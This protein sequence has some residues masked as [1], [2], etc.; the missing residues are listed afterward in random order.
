MRYELFD[1][2]KNAVAELLR[3]MQSMRRSYEEDDSLSAVSLTAPTGAGKTVVSAAVAEGLFYG[4]DLF[5]GD[6]RAVILWLSDS[7]SLNEQT[8]KRFDRATDLLSG[9]TTMEAIGPEFA[10]NHRKLMP[11]HVYFLNRQLLSARGRLANEAEG[12]RTFYDVLSETIEDPDIHLFL[13]IDEAHRGLGGDAT[14]DATNKTIYAKLIDGQDGKNPPMPIVVGISATP[15][16]F[17]AAMSGR[18]NRDTKAPVNVPVSEV[19]ESGLIKDTIELRTPK[20]AADTKHQDL[21]LACAKLAQASKNWKEYCTAHGISPVVIP[22]MVVQVEDKVSD[23]TLEA[24]CAQIHK[25]LPWLDISDCFA[26]VFGE[27]EDITTPAG[28]IPYCPPEDVAERTEIRVLFAKD[29]VSTGWDCP[30]AEV[31]YSRRK[32]NDPTYIAQLIGRMIRTPLARRIDSVEELNTVACY[33]PEY[34]AQTVESVVERLKEDNVP[35]ASANI[36]KNPADVGWFGDTKKNIERKLRKKQAAKDNA[37]AP[38]DASEIHEDALSNSADDDEFEVNTPDDEFDIEDIDDVIET[39]EELTEALSRIPKVDDDAIKES[40]EGI[41]TRQVRHDKPNAFLDLWDCI[42]VIMADIDPNSD[43]GENIQ[44]EFYNNIE[45]EIHKHPAEFKRAYGEITNTTISVKRV[46]PLTG[47]EFEDREETVQ[48]DADRMVA[49]YRRAVSVF[50][51]ASDL[52]KSYINRRREDELDSDAA[53]IGRICAVAACVE[54]IRG[55]EDWAEDETRELLDT[56]GP[57]RYAV[58]EENKE[59]W[60]RI[61]GNTLPYIERTLNIQASITRQNKEYDAYPKHI[62]SDSDGWAYLKLND[63]EKKVVRT[64]LARSLN[65]AWYRNQ[66]RNL[67]ASLSIPYFLNGEWENMYPDFIFFQQTTSGDIVRTIVDPHGDWL[68]DS[69]AKLKGYVKYLREHPDMFGSVQAVADERGGEC[70][71]LDLMLP[72]VQDAID[73]F[74]GSSAKELFT[75]PLSKTYKV[76]PE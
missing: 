58:S 62:I 31:I 5:P 24:I 30:R 39:K 26:N 37:P 44:E 72:A 55:M 49:F 22:L 41:V 43:L 71:Y 63:L 28:K 34:D 29:A 4:N 50:A 17:N 7:P 56:Y 10:K 21:T 14:P 67:N 18:K 15:E 66:S 60:D 13:F 61:E 25:T 54:V 23:A 65:V 74:I 68:G 45:G 40:F 19:R 38:G 8:M 57:Q 42:D 52:V 6:D 36:I 33:L 47:E 48:N 70:R 76:K 53:A 73:N 64:E 9:A 20:R 3:K 59:K 69:V 46:D 11:G 2:Q 12:G 75:G 35:V 1:F 32:R 16:R 27:H 51:G